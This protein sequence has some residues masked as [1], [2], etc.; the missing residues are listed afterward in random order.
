[1]DSVRRD[2]R[3]DERTTIYW[4]PVVKLEP[5]RETEVSFYTADMPGTYTVVLEGVT[6]DGQAI[7]KRTR[8]TVE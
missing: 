8:L 1:M 2:N 5:G 3:Y 6:R 7:R 4:N